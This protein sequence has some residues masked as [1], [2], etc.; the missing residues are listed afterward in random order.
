M[1]MRTGK[2]LR[3]AGRLCALA[4][5]PAIGAAHAQDLEPRAYL[6][7]PVG[8][9]FLVLGVGDSQG[10]LSVDP[11]LPVEDA[12]LRIQSGHLAYARILDL[13]GRSGKLDVVLPF[14]RLTGT[15][16]VA[17]QPREREISGL[18]DARLRLSINL[19][20]AP[21]LRLSEFGG[22]RRDFVLGAS[23]QVTPPI[24]QY[25]PSRA[26][27][28]GSH[29]WSVKPD[30]GFS[31]AFGA[32]TLDFTASA[33]FFS[34]NHDYFGGRSL[35][36]RPVYAVQANLSVDFGPSVWGAVGTTYYRGGR[37]VTDGVFGDATLSNSRAGMVIGVAIDR[38]QSIKFSYSDGLNTRTG[39][40][41]RTAV[42]AWQVRWGGGY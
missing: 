21:A 5:L 39:T 33:T 10:G 30:L 26:I 4:V 32:L 6:N 15:A 11:A 24:G 25:D 9:Q 3:R 18:G 28:L 13:G 14:A 22:Y 23:V 41:F 37:T 42:V 35:E 27:N 17:G 16:T 19:L 40:D 7:A 31:K 8:L 12:R 36:Q 2:A 1:R 34:T 38:F 20:G 29:R